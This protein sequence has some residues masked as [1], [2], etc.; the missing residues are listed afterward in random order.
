LIWNTPFTFTVYGSGNAVLAS[1]SYIEDASTDA[2]WINL[3]TVTAGDGE[4]RGTKRVFRMTVIGGPEPPFAI[5]L[6]QADRNLYNIAISTSGSANTSPAG[7]RIFAYSWTLLIP[8]TEW[9]TPARAFPYVDAGVTAVT[10]HNWD[11][12]RVAAAGVDVLTP[13]RTLSSP[14]SAVS[15]NAT[16]ATSTY[17]VIA[18]ETGSTWAIRCWA[19]T[20]SSVGSNIATVWVVD[21]TGRSLALFARS[22]NQPPP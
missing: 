8:A 13:Q 21:Q 2:R 14:A 20:S 11:Y 1:Q 4:L 15:T 5:G 22:T 19:D 3:A 17:A 12:D 9:A 7:A 6:Q 16:E 10:Q 18:G